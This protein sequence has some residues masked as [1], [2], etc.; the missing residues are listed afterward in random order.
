MIIC[1]HCISKK[2]DKDLGSI[3]VKK[4]NQGLNCFLFDKNMGH[5]M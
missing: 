4:I 1:L 5:N 3:L 2:I